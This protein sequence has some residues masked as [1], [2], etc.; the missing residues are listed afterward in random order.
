MMLM[1]YM[2]KIRAM[3]PY[4]QRKLDVGSEMTSAP[5]SSQGPDDSISTTTQEL[6]VSSVDRIVE[7]PLRKK[8]Q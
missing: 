7:A 6:G 4:E 3:V 5:E 1:L 2:P 8:R